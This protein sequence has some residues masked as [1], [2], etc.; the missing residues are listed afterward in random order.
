M[1]V[2]DGLAS[3]MRMHKRCVRHPIHPAAGPGP[4][5]AVE[6]GMADSAAAAEGLAAVAGGDEE[7]LPF[8]LHPLR[9][10]A[11]GSA[12]LGCVYPSPP[13]LGCVVGNAAITAL[14]VAVHHLTQRAPHHG[15][16]HLT[17]RAVPSIAARRGTTPEDLAATLQVPGCLFTVALFLF[18]G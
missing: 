4:V 16:A 7:Q 5:A 1:S 17:Q 2:D 14:C 11:G 15:V 18:Q 10:R 9:F 8:A 3:L 6:R 12:H 13:H